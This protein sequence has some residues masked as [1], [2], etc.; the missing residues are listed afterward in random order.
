MIGCVVSGQFVNTNPQVAG[1][2]ERRISFFFFFFFPFHLLLPL[3][4][5]FLFL[6]LL[7]S[8]S[9]SLIFPSPPGPNKLLF[10]IKTPKAF[11]HICLFLLGTQPVPQDRV[12][13]IYVTCEK[14]GI[15]GWWWWWW[16]SCCCCYYC[17]CC[18]EVVVRLLL[19]LLLFLSSWNTTCSSRSCCFDLCD[20]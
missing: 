20:V 14:L 17:Y 4:V 18:C 8:L 12:A 9:P 6:S 15:Q 10:D 7:L 13:L 19:L 5:F 2:F 3:L 1:L 11:R 16:C